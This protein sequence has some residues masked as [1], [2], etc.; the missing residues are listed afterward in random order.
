MNTPKLSI[1]ALLLAVNYQSVQAAESQGYTTESGLKIIPILESRFEHNDNVGR[2]SDSEDPESSTVFVVE[3]GVRIE[4]DRGGNQYSVSYQLGSGSYFDNS[5]DN[6]LDHKF[7]TN[8]FIRFN[9]RNGIALNYS[10]QYLHEERGTGLLAGDLYSL[11]AEEPVEY[12]VHNVNGTYVYGSE[13]ATG[14]LEFMLGYE[15]R[16]YQNYRGV[17]LPG[18]GFVSTEFKDH[19]EVSGAVTF[20]YRV[21]SATSLLFE[22]DAIDRQYDLNEANTGLS[23]DSLDMYYLVGA[24]WD[25]TGKTTGKLRFGLQDKQYDE[26]SKDDFQGFSWDLD[27]VWK[28]TMHSTF[29]LS[30]SQRARDP[31]QGSTYVDETSVSAGWKHY[32]VNNFYSRITGQVREDDYSNSEREDDLMTAGVTFGYE[33][34]DFADIG[35]GWKF[36]TNDSTTSGNSYDQN[37]WF[38]SADLLF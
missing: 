15:D 19:S 7:A 35:L 6:Y 17:D 28:P 34:L 36:E 13:E 37:I 11:A 18:I 22:V 3:P 2:Y 12:A 33:I 16:E 24:S 5:D 26:S 38:L 23:Q 14:R 27:L 32:W 21:T 8:N 4:S 10:Y 1:L 25:L 20:Y 30:G 29:A 31:E 9:A